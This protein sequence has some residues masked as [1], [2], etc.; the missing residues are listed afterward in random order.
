MIKVLFFSL[1]TLS[2]QA[3]AE[4]CSH[5]EKPDSYFRFVDGITEA[6]LSDERSIQ[7][8][9]F[10]L[11]HLNRA[12][13]FF[14]NLDSENPFLFECITIRTN[15]SVAWNR[16]T[17]FDSTQPMYNNSIV[18]P[19]GVNRF[20]QSAFDDGRAL[21]W[22]TEIWF[23]DPT[24]KKTCPEGHTEDPT[25]GQYC[26]SHS[27]GPSTKKQK[28]YYL[29][30]GAIPSV[31]YHEYAHIALQGAFP[32]LRWNRIPESFANYFAAAILG[33]GKV[34][35]DKEYFGEVRP[36]DRKLRT[37]L[38]SLK[39]YHPSI[40]ERAQQDP[41]GSRY[42]YDR[43]VPSLFW[44]SRKTLGDVKANQLAWRVAHK[45]NEDSLYLEVVEAIRDSLKENH[46]EYV[47]SEII[48][49]AGY[50][51]TLQDW[52]HNRFL[53]DND[54]NWLQLIDVLWPKD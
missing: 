32:S 51:S 47:Y 26:I 18:V 2:I 34:G 31:I 13:E 20:F 36:A 48:F 11:N 5:T 27:G 54:R 21:E 23:L 16:A 40:D 46:H 42:A 19:P 39:T 33:K 45:M 49:F 15:I 43:E 38:T 29:D 1:L 22:G 28:E 41:H 10:I 35:A 3:F 52:K 9:E 50:N 53:D 17:H 14:L 7:K 4:P 6:P 44:W 30:T 37:N 8:A 24:R 25:D 12:R